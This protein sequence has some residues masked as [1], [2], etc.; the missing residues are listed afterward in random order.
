MAGLRG[1]RAEGQSASGAAGLRRGSGAAAWRV[2][3]RDVAQLAPDEHDEHRRPD[4]REPERRRDAPPLARAR[5]PIPDP[6]TSPPNTPTMFTDPTRPWSAI[7]TAR[8]RTVIDVVPQTK[9]CAPN[10]KKIA[11]ATPACR[12]Q[13]ERRGA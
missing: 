11:I 13:R 2:V 12:G 3:V 6:T 9:A 10:T 5:P 8:W 1:R 7:G 4:E